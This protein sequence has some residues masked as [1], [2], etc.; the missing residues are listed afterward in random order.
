M[1]RDAAVT[2]ALNIL[3]VAAVL[4]EGLSDGESEKLS[5][6]ASTEP[7]FGYRAAADAL[8]TLRAFRCGN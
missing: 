1:G 7:A 8:R 6:L 2:A 3:S 5:A 4:L